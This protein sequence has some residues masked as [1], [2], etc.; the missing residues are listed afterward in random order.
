[1]NEAAKGTGIERD[2]VR[3]VTPGTV[4]EPGLLDSKANNNL[5]AV[6][7]SA[8]SAGPAA[9][10]RSLANAEAGLAVADI[11]TGEFYRRLASAKTLPTTSQP[12]VGDFEAAYARLAEE[13][14]GIVSIHLSGKLSG[15]VGAAAAA[16]TSFP[17]CTIEVIDSESASFGCGIAVVRAAQAAKASQSVLWMTNSITARFPRATSASSSFNS[18][19]SSSIERRS[20]L[21][22][23]GAVFTRGLSAW[24][25]RMTSWRLAAS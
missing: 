8:R 12:S 18:C 22:T 20:S 4:V 25:C 6:L 19:S 10:R 2:V 9:S 16:T 11:T 24:T 15:T 7:A 23:G 17:H 21:G 5:V 14:T 1:M 3:V 13:T